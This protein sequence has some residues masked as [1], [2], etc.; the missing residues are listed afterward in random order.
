MKHIYVVLGENF[1]NSENIVEK[2]EV[3]E[4]FY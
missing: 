2:E 3:Y 1:D 4:W